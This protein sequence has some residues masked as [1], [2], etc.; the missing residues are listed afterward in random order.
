MR[1]ELELYEILVLLDPNLI[2]NEVATKI[3]FYQDFL[4]AK[5]SKV[6]VQ[7]QGRKGLRYTIKKFEAASFIQMVFLGNGQLVESLNSTLR[8]DERVLR[9]IVTKLNEP[10]LV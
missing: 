6:M 3:E 8:R 1:K 5:G 9:H 2:D 4:T 7:N 10:L